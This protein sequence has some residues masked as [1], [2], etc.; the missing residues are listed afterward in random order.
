MTYLTKSEFAARRGWSKSYVSKLASQDRLVLTEGGKVDV[1]ATETLL[2]ESADPSKAAVTARHEENRIDRDVRSQL[3]PA[4]DAPAVQPAVQ[5]PGK[6][7]D[8]QKARAHR[9][10]YLAQLAEAEFNRVQGNLV[11][12]KCV[13]DAA[14]TAGRTLRDLVFGLAP[15]LAAELT[16][17]NDSWE[18]EKHLT[19]A[20]RQVFEDAAKMSD[21]D[22]EQAMTQS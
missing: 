1:E 17:M 3:V 11:E 9:E 5:Q 22:L 13:E 21:A 15:Q 16:G 2:A 14:F 19:G 18:I 7:L 10:F 4:S 8:F 12:R 6:G 20:F